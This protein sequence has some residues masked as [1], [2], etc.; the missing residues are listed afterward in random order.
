M[1]TKLV[2]KVE[3][4]KIVVSKDGSGDF[5][6]VQEAINSVPENN[7][8]PVIIYIKNGIYK[9]VVTVSENKRFISLVGESSLNTI[10]TYDNFAGKVKENGENVG[11]SGSASVYLLAD[12]TRVENITLENS[13]DDSLEIDPVK[14]NGRQAV[15]VFT[16]GQHVYFNNVRFLG[17]QDTLYVH[18]GT[19]YYYNCYIEGDVDFIFG[20]AQAVFNQCQIHSLDRGSKVDNGYVTAAS[21]FI[22]EPFG[23]MII[24]SK[25]TSNAPPKTVYLGRP[26]PAGG[27]PDAIGSVLITECELGEHIIIEGWTS[28]NGRLEPEEARLYE[29]KN[30][31]P[32]AA[33]HVKRRQLSEEEVKDWSIQNVLKGWEISELVCK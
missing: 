16:S 24:N 11:T 9:E 17:K 20:A 23:I 32:G 15:A 3:T 27:N 25:F 21:T 2:N 13:Y 26:W 10:I 14:I 18:K 1:V 30:F 28:M 19:M 12:E 5:K 7:V 8:N 6:T 4:N 31:G 22:S 29:Y 33:T